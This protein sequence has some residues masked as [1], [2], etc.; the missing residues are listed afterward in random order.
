MPD[1]NEQYY[2]DL[3][4]SS[5][6]RYGLDPD[7]FESQIQMESGFRPGVE[8]SSGAQGI[9]QIIPKYHQGVDPWNPE[10]ALD[11]AAKLMSG[12]LQNYGGDMRK[13]LTAYHAGPGTLQ[14]V[15]LRTN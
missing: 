4:R 10:E 11:Y 2:R 15:Q 12:H 1:P 3:A 6:I 14:E 9:A 13:A 7:I 8:S 5:A